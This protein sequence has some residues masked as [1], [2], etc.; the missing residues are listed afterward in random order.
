MSA[1]PPVLCT[2]VRKGPRSGFTILE[3]AVAVTIV[4][5]AAVAS[6]AAFAAELR[7]ADR[8]RTALV[9]EALLEESM[10]LTRV[11][12]VDALASLPDSLRDGEF[13]PPFEGY[14]WERAVRIV[15]GAPGLFEATVTVRQRPSSEEGSGSAMLGNRGSEGRTLS[16]RLYR[17]AAARAA[18]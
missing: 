6:L 4:G 17:Q 18:Q 2:A 14:A 9:V 5:L 8:A 7:A 13:P 11:L 3:A 15:P 12:P 16:T 1:D 10:A